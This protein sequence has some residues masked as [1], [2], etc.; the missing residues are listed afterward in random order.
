MNDELMKLRLASS[1]GKAI[2]SHLNI[3]QGLDF[4]LY[5]IQS[6]KREVGLMENT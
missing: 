2:S 1:S 4:D 6:V 5:S 3:S